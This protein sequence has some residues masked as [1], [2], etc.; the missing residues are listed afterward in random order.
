[1]W[2][3]RLGLIVL[4]FWVL[5]C[6]ARLT[7][8]VEPAETP[9]GEEAAPLFGFFKQQIPES[10]GYLFILPSEFGSDTGLGPRL[11][12]ELYPRTYDDIRGSQDEQTVRDLMRRENLR[13]VVVTD[14][15]LYPQ[16]HWVRQPRD[17]LKRAN[18]DADRYVLE[19]VS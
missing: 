6:V 5:V 13:Y 10:A 3:Q 2:R 14:A 16:T 15:T 8:L 17:W 12:Y 11:R 7:R 1:M 4:G 18:F 9:P 19:V